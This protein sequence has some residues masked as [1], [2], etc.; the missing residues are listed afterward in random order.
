MPANLRMLNLPAQVLAQL[1]ERLRASNFTGYLGH[2]TWL[3]GLG[4]QAGHSSIHAYAQRNKQRIKAG[5]AHGS[6]DQAGADSKS[7]D[8]RIQCLQVAA[9]VAA[10]AELKTVAEDLYQWATRR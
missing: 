3:Q 10:P 8:Q 2:A 6:A 5:V 4:H 1:D 7:A 9:A